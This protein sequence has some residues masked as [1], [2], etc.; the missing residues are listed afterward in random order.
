[1][2]IQTW[3]TDLVAEQAMED[4]H[5]LYW[6]RMIDLVAEP[7]LRSARVLDFGCNQG[8]FLRLLHARKPFARALGIDIARAAVEVAR[9]RRTTEPVDYRVVQLLDEVAET[10]DIAFSHEVVYLIEDI[11]AHARAMHARLA[12]G[13]VYYVAIGCHTD[14]PAWPEWAV[15]I[16]RKSNLPV[17]GRSLEQ[18]AAAFA[19]AGFA[20]EARPFDLGDRFLSMDASEH[21]SR[22]F[23]D[24]LA[25]VER[26]KT[27]F[28]LTRR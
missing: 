22:R 5:D 6:N 18:Y 13:G 20:L 14:N 8:G 28:R 27:L 10:F 25:Y 26:V 3:T 4:G 24:R 2:T 16:P 9:R 19:A 12:P 23:A 21:P 1:M 7:D 11:D 17:F 15:E